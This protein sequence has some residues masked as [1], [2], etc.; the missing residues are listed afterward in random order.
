M[1][2]AS[3]LI[4]SVNRKLVTGLVIRILLLSFL[5]H[6]NRDFVFFSRWTVESSLASSFRSTSRLLRTVSRIED[7]IA[8]RNS[9]AAST[10]TNTLVTMTLAFS[11]FTGK[12]DAF[13]GS[14]IVRCTLPIRRLVS[15]E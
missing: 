1:R 11:G 13:G 6:G 4:V 5:A 9:T 3:F 2:L 12:P 10:M 14:S 7:S 8:R 15:T